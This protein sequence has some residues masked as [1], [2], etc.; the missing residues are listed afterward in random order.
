MLLLILLIFVPLT[1]SFCVAFL[2]HHLDA[3]MISPFPVG[4]WTP[5]I[6]M[7]PWVNTSQPPTTSRSV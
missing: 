3:I 5:S 6:N 4:I 7:V 2:V 1:F